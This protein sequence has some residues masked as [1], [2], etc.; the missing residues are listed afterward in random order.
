MLGPN[1][2]QNL[3]LR[4]EW[5]VLPR[6]AS[7]IF[8]QL[9]DMTR[10][11]NFTY[12]AK[13]SFLQIYNEKLFDLLRSGSEDSDLRIREIPRGKPA[14]KR[15][16]QPSSSVVTRPSEVFITGLSE[17]RVQTADDILRILS[18]GTQSRATRS[19]NYNATSS[20]S[21]AI[22]QIAF[23]IEKRE[24][25]GQVILYRFISRIHHDQ[26]SFCD[27]VCRSKLSLVDLAGSEKMLAIGGDDTMH[28]ANH[29]K[30]LTSINQSLSSLGNVI[31]ALSSKTRAHIPYRDSKLTRILQVLCHVY[32]F[33]L[34]LR[35]SWIGLSRRKHQDHIN[36][37]CCSYTHPLLRDGQYTAIR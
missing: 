17:F 33:P 30:E 16:T 8:N 11:G 26:S 34:R 12:A 15:S 31:S 7:Y 29:L 14:C 4:N 6:S 27:L 10:Q 35:F 37:L 18:V 3:N 1:G 9:Q 22:L 24:D 19:T 23:E 32:L 20:R 21:H 5:G 13:A 2:G 28:T 25:N 36:R